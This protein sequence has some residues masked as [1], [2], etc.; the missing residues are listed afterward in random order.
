[1]LTV[2]CG[3][4]GIARVSGL[5]VP[6]MSLGFLIASL[7]VI[8]LDYRALPDAVGKILSGALSIKSAARAHWAL[9]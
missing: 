2:S 9:R 5:L 6:V 7:A 8:A 1:M 3:L 4:S